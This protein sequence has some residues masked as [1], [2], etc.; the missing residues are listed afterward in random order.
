MSQTWLISCLQRCQ[1]SLS[2]STNSFLS[3]LRSQLR[4]SFEKKWCLIPAQSATNSWCHQSTNP[5]SCFL[6][7]I[8]SASSVLNS[9]RKR[10]NNVL[11]AE[12]PITRWHPIFH[13]RTWFWQPMKIQESP[14]CQVLKCAR[15]SSLTRLARHFISSRE[16]SP[17]K[18]WARSQAAKLIHTSSNTECL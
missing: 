6:V 1:Q 12:V 8:L 4:T 9:M 13:Y 7:V 10:K 2:R 16:K 3:N 5:L 17:N 11:F 18:T 15:L 14:Q